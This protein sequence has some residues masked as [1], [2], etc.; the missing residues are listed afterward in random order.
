[1]TQLPI[2]SSIALPIVSSITLPIVSSI[3]LPS[4]INEI[5]YYYRYF[6]P[7]KVNMKTV[8]KEYHE[9]CVLTTDDICQSELKWIIKDD[10]HKPI[11]WHG[12]LR[13]ND[14]YCTPNQYISRFTM[15]GLPF[16]FL[17]QYRVKKPT[18]Y[19][20]S[21]GFE[22]PYAYRTYDYTYKY[23]YGHGYKKNR[24]KKK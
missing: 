18:R 16:V 14:L 5:L 13:I 22:H 2:V 6:V 8:I 11:W 24:K 7:W 9:K 23:K 4:L 21:S 12:I 10:R 17:Q 20:Y 3:A 1:M 19:Y 15:R